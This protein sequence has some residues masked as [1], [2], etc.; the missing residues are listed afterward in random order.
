MKKIVIAID[1]FSSCGKSTM[2]KD[3]AHHLGYIYV[4]T[5]AMYRAVTLYALRNNLFIEDNSKVDE[6]SLQQAIPPVSYTHLT[7]PT[8]ER[9]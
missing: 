8:T 9:V 4:D 3:L 1:G 6:A 7:L 2:A 5:G